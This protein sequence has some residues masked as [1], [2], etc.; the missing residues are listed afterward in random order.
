M[1]LDTFW[2]IKVNLR[3]K[4]APIFC[5]ISVPPKACLV[6]TS[7]I[8]IYCFASP[9]RNSVSTI[10]SQLGCYYMASMGASGTSWLNAYNIMDI[11]DEA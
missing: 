2:Y 9:Y 6:N 5:R 8:D 4:G 7:D 10:M 3:L 1:Q 11:I